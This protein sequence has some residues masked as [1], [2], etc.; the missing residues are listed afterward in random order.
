MILSYTYRVE[1]TPRQATARA[2]MLGDFC[3]RYNAGL[4]QP[5]PIGAV[6]YR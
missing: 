5:K 6:A 2:A 4:Q 3:D 1:P